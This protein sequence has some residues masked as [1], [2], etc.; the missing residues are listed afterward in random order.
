ML[1]ETSGRYHYYVDSKGNSAPKILLK[2]NGSAIIKRVDL[3]AGNDCLSSHENLNKCRFRFDLPF[4]MSSKLVSPR[5][6]EFFNDAELN[7]L[8]EKMRK[9]YRLNVQND[10]LEIR[11][12]EKYLKNE[13]GANYR[14]HKVAK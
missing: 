2:N 3:Y 6:L 11:N 1:F 9:K 13:F 14:F 4:I 10:L 8:T 12:F 7:I 5:K